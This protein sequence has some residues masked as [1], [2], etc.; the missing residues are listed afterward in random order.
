MKPPTTRRGFL[1]STLATGVGL[2]I[3][4]SR[5]A[6]GYQANDRLNIACIGVAGMGWGN[7]A[8]VSSQNIVALCDVSGSVW[9][10]A[11]A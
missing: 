5:L 4:D 2:L 1:K 6:F 9:S 8:N 10:A 7:L 3:S 11:R